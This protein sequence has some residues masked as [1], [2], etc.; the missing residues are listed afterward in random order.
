[1][2]VTLWIIVAFICGALPMSVWLGRLVLKTDIRQYG[3]GNPGAANV[4]RAGGA[5]W[6]VTAILLDSFKGAIPVW[7]AQFGLGI[8][9]MALAAVT[10]APVLGHAISPFIGFKG[11]KALA[12]TF[13][14]W[15][16]LTLW[17]GPTLLGICFGLWLGLL[18]V[19]GWAV[20]FGS[21]SFLVC[22]L[23]LQVGSTWL[24]VWLGITAI[25]FWKHLADFRRPIQLR[26]LATNR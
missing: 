4:W 19:E 22:L 26:L 2:M 13:G 24:V 1:M 18:T 25:L 8:D 20:F 6:G 7:I 23:L 17:L 15:C 16:G 14:V 11:G 21:L 9:G 10:I 5:K 3:D 12:V